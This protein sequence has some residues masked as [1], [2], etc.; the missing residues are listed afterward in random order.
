MSWMALAK[1]LLFAILLRPSTL[2][3]TER[4]SKKVNYTH[5]SYCLP[6]RQHFK[7][8]EGLLPPTC[9]PVVISDPRRQAGRSRMGILGPLLD[10]PGTH[11]WMGTCSNQ[12]KG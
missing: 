7:V 10:R 8:S 4:N 3:V 1:S 12:Q 2:R 11:F 5:P 9:L 6:S